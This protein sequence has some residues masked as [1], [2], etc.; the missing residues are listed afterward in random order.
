[1]KYEQ[2][3]GD[4]NLDNGSFI[5]VYILS[6]SRKI[7]HEAVWNLN[8]NDVVVKLIV[9]NEEMFNFDLDELSKDYKFDTSKHEAGFTF[10]IQ[11]YDNNRWVYKP[12]HPVEI[13]EHFKIQMKAT[14]NNAALYRGITGWRAR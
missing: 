2:W 8:R 7:V 6:G 10:G 11:E 5:D 12:S 4:Q 3:T 13:T 9:D 1:M 14:K